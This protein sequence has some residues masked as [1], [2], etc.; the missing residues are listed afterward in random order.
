MSTSVRVHLWAEPLNP[1][2]PS[3]IAIDLNYGAG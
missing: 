1:L 3:A 2:D